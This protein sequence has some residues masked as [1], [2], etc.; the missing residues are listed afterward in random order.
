MAYMRYVGRRSHC[1]SRRS[2]TARSQLKLGAS[3]RRPRKQLGARTNGPCRLGR[4]T[5]SKA[6]QPLAMRPRAMSRP[7]TFAARASQGGFACDCGSCSARDSRRSFSRPN[8]RPPALA[9]RRSSS[10]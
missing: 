5:R 3:R 10:P 2:K 6:R 7:W 4:E 1:R 8:S 9:A